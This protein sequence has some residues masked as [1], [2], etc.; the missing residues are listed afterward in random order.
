MVPMPTPMSNKW[1]IA[2]LLQRT[3]EVHKEM[4]LYRFANGL[5]I[6]AEVFQKEDRLRIPPLR[7]IR[8]VV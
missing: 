2:D 5:R 4:I 1:K 7:A 6:K 8:R 3:A